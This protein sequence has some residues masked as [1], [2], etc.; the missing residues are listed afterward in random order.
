MFL[1]ILTTFYEVAPSLNTLKTPIPP[2][3][4]LPDLFLKMLIVLVSGGEF[5]NL[6]A[7]DAFH[8]Q[9]RQSCM[10]HMFQDAARRSTPRGMYLLG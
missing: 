3:C 4:G 8:K 10:E 5:R 9:D 7:G 6:K 2:S 1:K